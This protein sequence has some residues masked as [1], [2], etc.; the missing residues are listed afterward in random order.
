[1]DKEWD[2]LSP[3]LSYLQADFWGNTEYR[4]NKCMG[5]IF[6]LRQGLELLFCNEDCAI[7]KRRDFMK[8]SYPIAAGGKRHI[9]SY[10]EL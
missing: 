10:S 4:Y 1:M 8:W 3:S 6:T 5:L 7:R 9:Q 2:L